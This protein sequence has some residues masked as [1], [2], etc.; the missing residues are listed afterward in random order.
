MALTALGLASIAR[1]SPPL[2]ARGYWELPP[3]LVPAILGPALA[4]IG[5]ADPLA[6]RFPESAPVRL[7]AAWSRRVTR[8]YVAHWL[9]VAWGIGVVGYL[10][11]DLPTTLVAIVLVVAAVDLVGREW[12]APMLRL[13][14]R[15]G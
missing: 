11:L 8:I 9:V 3:I 13:A 6:R 1:F 7:C 5:L 2:D 15:P 12:S 4:W 14:R 10:A